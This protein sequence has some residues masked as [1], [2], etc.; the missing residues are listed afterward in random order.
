[1]KRIHLFVAMVLTVL[2]LTACGG[3][4]APESTP[5]PGPSASPGGEQLSQNEQLFL[6]IKESTPLPEIPLVD[7]AGNEVILKA[8]EGEILVINFWASW[9]GYCIKEIP[10]FNEV[11]EKLQGDGVRIVAVN[12]LDSAGDPYT[13][14]EIQAAFAEEQRLGVAFTGYVDRNNEA[15]LQFAIRSVPMTIFVD[16]G[17]NIVLRY[18]GMFQSAEELTEWLTYVQ[19]YAGQ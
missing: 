12:V 17:N 7:S 3:S 1:M 14:E 16:G 4:G 10:Y 2:A 19:K 6:Q 9:C 8:Q 13:Q 5:G 15:A 11:H 18:P